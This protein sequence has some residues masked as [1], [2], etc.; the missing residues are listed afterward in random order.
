MIYTEIHK[1]E[2]VRGVVFKW[3]EENGT[4]HCFY[5]YKGCVGKGQGDTLKEA[6][7]CAKL[8]AKSAYTSKL[9]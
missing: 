2:I 7:E 6:K 1:P 8:S 4:Y 3:L 9:S 5:R